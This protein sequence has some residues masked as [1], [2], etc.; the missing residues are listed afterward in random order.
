MIDVDLDSAPSGKTTK[1]QPCGLSIWLDQVREDKRAGVLAVI[2]GQSQAAEVGR[3]LM[4]QE[5]SPGGDL[6]QAVRRHRNRSCA[7]CREAGR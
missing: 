4:T 2:H 1:H 3:W 7:F 6:A 5:G